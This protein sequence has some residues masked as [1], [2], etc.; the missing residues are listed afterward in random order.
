MGGF[1]GPTTGWVGWVWIGML[2]EMEQ[3][4]NLF[5]ALTFANDDGKRKKVAYN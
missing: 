4:N 3:P 5:P 1:C 2:I